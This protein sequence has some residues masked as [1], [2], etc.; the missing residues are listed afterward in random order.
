[1]IKGVEELRT[2]RLYRDLKEQ[3]PPLAV[4]KRVQSQVSSC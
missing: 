2:F 1:V 4:E 3:F